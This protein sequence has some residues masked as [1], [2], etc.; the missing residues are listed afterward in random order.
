MQRKSFSRLLVLLIC[1][2]VFQTYPLHEK[3]HAAV[4][5][6]S[7]CFGGSQ[8]SYFSYP[9]GQTIG[10]SSFTLEMWVKPKT[11]SDY[12][13]FL[14]TGYRA[15]GGSYLGY[16]RDVGV[17]KKIIFYNGETI[18][19][20]G[21]NLLATDAQQKVPLGVWSHVAF[22]RDT[23]TAK[24]YMY[25]NG[26]KVNE[27]A[28]SNY[29]FAKTQLEIG[30]NFDGCMTSV[31]LAKSALY[32]STFTP[33]ALGTFSLAPVGT[34]VLVGIT[35]SGNTISNIGTSG[36]IAGGGTYT[37]ESIKSSARTM[38][39][40]ATSYSLKYGE[41]QTVVANVSAGIGSISYS[42]GVSTACT[43]N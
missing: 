40:T 13:S 27:G 20:N 12:M 35:A 23:A 8:T 19:S 42:A 1:A 11:W 26:I 39:F 33:A 29:N 9:T 17:D 25:I 43:V 3:A 24:N 22:V 7:I 34:D 5:S 32:A 2:G 37:Y 28:Y 21:S 31:R 15:G 4:G 36:A 10:T 41:T 16:N 6:Q 38:V 30:R 14:D 18:G